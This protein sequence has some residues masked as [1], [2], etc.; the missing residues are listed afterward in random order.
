[1]T[2]ISKKQRVALKQISELESKRNR[3]IILGVVSIGLA[4]VVFFG[5]NLLTYNFG[6]IP[7]TEMIPRAIVYTFAM[8]VAGYCG[9]MFM[10]ASQK[11]RKIEGYRQQASISRDMLEAWKNGE[12]DE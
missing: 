10:H 5:Y 4:A 2:K 12:Y 7:E 8:V 6:I 11:K 9:I 1:M 3:D